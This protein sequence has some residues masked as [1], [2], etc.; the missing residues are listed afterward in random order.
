ME[1]IFIILFFVLVFSIIGFIVINIFTKTKNKKVNNKINNLSKEDKLIAVDELRK[2]VRSNPEN[3]TA[4]EKLAEALFDVKSYVPAIKEFL[5]LIDNS[6]TH[7]ELNELKYTIRVADTYLKLENYNDAKKYYLLAK[8]T[9]DL[10]FYVNSNLGKIEI[11][12]KNYD[13][14]FFYLNVASKVSPEDLDVQKSLGIC[15][16]HLNRFNEAREALVK[17]FSKNQDDAETNYFLGFSLANLSRN[18]EALKVFAKIEKNPQ[19]A[20]VVLCEMALIHKKMKMYIQSIEEYE[21]LL[22]NNYF[23]GDSLLEVY[24]NLGD[25][26]VNIHN[27]AKAIQVWQKLASINSNYK[28]VQTKLET[29]SQL[30]S[31]SMLERYLLGSVN[32]FTNI[33][34]LIVKFYIAKYAKL[35]GTIKFLNIKLN[36]D[37]TLEMY[38][39]IS[40]GNFIEQV[41]FCFMR[42]TTTVGDL[43]LRNLYNQLRE[44]KIDRGICI[45]AGNF[46]P[47]AKNFVES[48]MIELIE[49]NQLIDILQSISSMLKNDS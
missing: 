7:K 11:I 20:G 37:N 42:S 24:Y 1:I 29:Y 38:V 41:Y 13:K 23:K 33:G 36:T 44:Q 39:E 40:S 28:D 26:Y 34:K 5:T 18:E 35:K 17:V 4:R 47:T 14:A 48:R 10:D 49:K 15:F 31:N 45:T 32:Q 8:K 21:K 9:D 16:Y 19:Y 2:I 30:N 27:L 43:I 3:F 22:Q 25:C 6:T 12:E 46:S